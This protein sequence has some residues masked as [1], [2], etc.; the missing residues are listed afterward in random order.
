MLL[1]IMCTIRAAFDVGSACLARL[2]KIMQDQRSSEKPWEEVTRYSDVLPKDCEMPESAGLQSQPEGT[3]VTFRNTSHHDKVGKQ[4]HN[5]KNNV[6]LQRFLEFMGL[7]STPNGC[8]EGSHC[9]TFF[10]I[11]WCKPLTRGIHSIPTNV[12]AAV[13]LSFLEEDSLIKISVGT[14]HS[15]LKQ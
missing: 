1:A 6:V 14:F 5:A 3:I 4:S 8:Q 7:N 11:Q 9:S 10:P 2:R 13:F 12:H 15:W